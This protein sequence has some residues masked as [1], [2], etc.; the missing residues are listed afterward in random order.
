MTYRVLVESP[1]GSS[2]EARAILDSASSASFVS[3]QLTQTLCLTRSHQN[4]RISGIAGLFRNSPFQ[5][6]A[7]FRISPSRHPNKKFEV[8]AVVVLRVTCDL[9][10][11]PVSFDSSWKHLED[12]TLADPDFGH[13]GR[14]DILLGVNIFVETLL[15]G[16]WIG[17]PDSPS[18]FETE[19]GWVLAGCLDMSDSHHVASH[20]ALLATSDELLRQFLED[21]GR[22]KRRTSSYIRRALCPTTL[23][24]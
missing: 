19:F 2:I 12:L 20:H 17:P 7:S 22:S 23:Q 24:G 9:P 6:I 18:G 1:D 3:E 8:S 14:I 4:T 16:R 10:L 5:S 11:Q 15:H 13:P 21:R